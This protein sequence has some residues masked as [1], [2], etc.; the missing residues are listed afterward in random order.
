MPL[1][2]PESLYGSTKQV[3]PYVGRLA[4]KVLQ[5]GSLDEI[6]RQPVIDVAAYT[7]WFVLSRGMVNPPAEQANFHADLLW[8]EL[9]RRLRKKLS[10]LEA[11]ERLTAIA[12]TGLEHAWWFASLLQSQSYQLVRR[13]SLQLRFLAH[14]ETHWH[15]LVSVGARY[16]PLGDLE[17]SPTLVS[18]CLARQGAPILTPPFLPLSSPRLLG[19]LGDLPGRRMQRL[20][21]Q[22]R[23]SDA[24]ALLTGYGE[25]TAL[26]LAEHLVDAGHDELACQAVRALNFADPH[27]IVRDWLADEGNPRRT[28]R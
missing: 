24:V 5:D 23:T 18:F 27:G 15:S 22:G 25:I 9:E 14:A 8:K 13:A 1:M 21:A 3:R 4:T 2:F 12:A 16:A 19:L 20:V 28:V 11:S 26:S 6:L 17:R 7:G 10:W